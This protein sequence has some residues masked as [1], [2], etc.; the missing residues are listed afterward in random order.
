MSKH[1][2]RKRI[3]YFLSLADVKVGGDRPWDLQVYNDNFFSRVMA[4]GSLGLGESYVDNWWESN[5]LDEF[6]CRILRADLNEKFKC[7][8]DTYN[9]LIAK[10]LNRQNKSRAFQVGQKHYDIGNDLYQHM[11]DK[12]MIYSCGYWHN[13]SVLDKAQD[14]KLDLVCRK[15]GIESGMKVLDI[16]CGWGGTAKFIAENCQAD[17]IGITVSEKQAEL[18][19]QFCKG[20]P[21]DIRLQDYRTLNEKFDRILSIGMFEHVGYKNYKSYMQSVRRNLKDNGLFL[22]HTIGNNRSVPTID[23]WIERYIFPNSM[24]PSA[25]QISTA[26]EDVFVL[27]DWH[28]FGVDYDKTLIQWFVN[29]DR[30]WPVLKDYYDERFYRMWKYYLLSCAGSFRAR[31]NQ[32]WQIVFS[33][34]GIPG[35]YQ[36]PR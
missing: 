9:C 12:R 26:A 2:F 36:A 7:C 5:K 11:L 1:I 8:K 20:L 27:E 22:L 24:I 35:G 30:N 19:K 13:V 3:E 4:D 25:K 17:V 28:N 31:K 34:D 18:A 6:F 29:F 15:L 33:K 23:T 10:I 14:A 32:V 21:I 16:G